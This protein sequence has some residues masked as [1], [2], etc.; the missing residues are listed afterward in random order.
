MPSE[1]AQ[2]LMGHKPAGAFASLNPSNA[3][4]NPR[5]HPIPRACWAG[6]YRLSATDYIADFPGYTPNNFDWILPAEV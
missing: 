6:G 5:G 1:T 4:S 2:W 3:S